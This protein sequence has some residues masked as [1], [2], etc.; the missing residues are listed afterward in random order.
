MCDRTRALGRRPPR[1]KKQRYSIYNISIKSL[2]NLR[3]AKDYSRRRKVYRTKNRDTKIYKGKR[4]KR[5]RGRR[6]RFLKGSHFLEVQAPLPAVSRPGPCWGLTDPSL[7][8]CYRDSPK[9]GAPTREDK[10]EIRDLETQAHTCTNITHERVT[11]TTRATREMTL[12]TP[13]TLL[14]K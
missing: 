1:R 6:R 10:E 14:E 12:E 7:A 2:Q 5:S 9:K 13:K 11:T 8:R 3:K 4:P